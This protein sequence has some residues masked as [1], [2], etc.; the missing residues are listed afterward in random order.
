MPARPALDMQMGAEGGPGG[1]SHFLVG[2]RQSAGKTGGLFGIAPVAKQAITHFNRPCGGVA[3]VSSAVPGTFRTR[4]FVLKKS[5]NQSPTSAL[6]D[7]QDK[8]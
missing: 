5:V 2:G 8:T 3:R 1:C 4:A 7:V 6:L